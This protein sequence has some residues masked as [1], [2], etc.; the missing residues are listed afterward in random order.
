MDRSYRKSCCFLALGLA[1]VVHPWIAGSG[2]A[3]SEARPLEVK[4]DA[5][6]RALGRTMGSGR[7][8]VLV[9]TLANQPD[10]QVGWRALKTMPKFQ[11]LSR[12]GQFIELNA[13]SEQAAMTRFGITSFPALRVFRKGPEGLV[14]AASQDGLKDAYAMIGW[15]STAGIEAATSSPVPSIDPSLV[16]ANYPSP[17]GQGP[18][19]PPPPSA[20]APPPAAPP[21][22]VS[23]PVTSVYSAPGPGPV[24][25]SAPTTPVVFQPQASQIVVGPTPPPNIFIASGPSTPPNITM[26]APAAP[27]TPPQL[28]LGAPS[29]PAA[30]PGLAPAAPP[31]QAQSGPAALALGYVLT[32]PGVIDRILGAI[33]RLLA[34]RSNPRIQMAPSMPATFGAPAQMIPAPS[35]LA[36]PV[37]AAAAAPPAYLLQE[38]ASALPT[39]LVKVPEGPTASPQSPCAVGS[40][41]HPGHGPA[42]SRSAPR[43]S[44]FFG[45]VR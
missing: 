44:R 24:V 26:M 23:L 21:A 22:T 45:W 14:L 18:T 31:N 33:G 42:A 40:C 11:A 16:Q 30:A 43:K 38:A 36:Q 12:A 39:A 6:T 4:A 32:N 20:P 28:M 13:G 37:Q 19:P 29:A 2:R 41:G 1:C 9:V 7:P 3:E 25:L 5:L 27:A 8:T 10:T 35:Y 15:L 34:S 17:S